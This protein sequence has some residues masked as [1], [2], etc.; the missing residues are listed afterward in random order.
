M[1]PRPSVCLHSK[2][3]PQRRMLSD[4]TPAAT[5]DKGIILALALTAVS[6][7]PIAPSFGLGVQNELLSDCQAATVSCVS[8]QDDTPSSFMEPWEYDEDVN[9]LQARLIAIVKS[10]P[11][12]SL[13]VREARYLRFEVKPSATTTDDVEFFFPSQD[14]VVHF[15]S[16]RHGGSFDFLQ[17]RRRIDRIR[18]KA[19]LVAI[20]ILRN[21][22]PSINIFETPFDGFG[23]SAVDVDA[24]I[25]NNSLGTR[26]VR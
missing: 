10:E 12:T 16:A 18:Q 7:L 17:N 24:L 25:E 9:E 20:P 26:T 8:S 13:V 1:A 15:R 6:F 19:K 23:P 14:N 2:E 4:S 5:G 21:R 11:H 3:Q 22:I